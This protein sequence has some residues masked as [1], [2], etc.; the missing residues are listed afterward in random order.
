[1]P[2]HKYKNYSLHYE[3]YGDG[4]TAL[5]LIHG[6]FGDNNSWKYQINYFSD[7]Y[8]IIAIDLFE[9]GLSSKNIDP[10]DVTHL[11][12]EAAVDLMKTIG[13]PYFALG[14]SFAGYVMP[15][16]IK[17]DGDRL[18][19]AVFIDS[20]Y[21]GNWQ[22]LETRIRFGEV[23]LAL[24]DER[25]AAESEFWYNSLIA[26]NAKQEDR[27][28]ILSSFRKGNYRQTFE[29][30]AKCRK[31]LI[32]YPAKETPIR[33]HQ[34]IFILENGVG[35]KPEF[36]KS[37]VNYFKL[38]DYYLFENAG[39]FFHITQ[40]EQFNKVLEYFLEENN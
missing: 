32:K 9:H 12:A 40:H 4:K 39:H 36:I 22:I 38:A 34:K 16:I 2:I 13:L 28:L 6:L 20:T 19:G 5:L 23:K 30:V 33:E 37:W 11:D 31:F 24:E 18:K 15:E 3:K 14:H 8:T 29:S 35:K 17:L 21:L 7:K 26:K 27:D 10:I 25:L 1:M